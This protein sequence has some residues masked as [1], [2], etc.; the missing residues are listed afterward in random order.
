M[1]SLA[2]LDQSNTYSQDKFESDASDDFLSRLAEAE[3]NTPT[4]R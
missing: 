3:S 4:P 1:A 2:L